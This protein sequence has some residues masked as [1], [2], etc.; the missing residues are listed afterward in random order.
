MPARGIAV[1][2]ARARRF[3]LV[4]GP[5]L[6]AA[7]LAA[8]PLLVSPILRAQESSGTAIARAQG[9]T[10]SELIRKLE[11]DDWAPPYFAGHVTIFD[12][13][14]EDRRLKE[15][16]AEPYTLVEVG[17]YSYRVSPLRADEGRRLFFLYDFGSADNWRTNERYMWYALGVSSAQDLSSRFGILVE[18]RGHLM[19]IVGMPDPDGRLDYGWSCAMCHASLDAQGRVVAGAPNHLYDSG[20]IRHRGLVEN[21]P[22]PGYAVP[23]YVDRDIPLERLTSMGP[24]RMDRNSDRVENPVKIPSLWGLRENRSGLYANGG[25]PN[26]WFA[27]ARHNGGVHPSS[28]YIEAMIAYLLEIEPPP[29]P[30]M[31]GEAESRGEDVFKRAGCGSCHSGP[32]YTN[33][34]VVPVETI[35]TDA[36][37][38][39]QEFPK[40]YRVPSLRR[41]DLDRLFLHDGSIAALADLFSRKRT[42]TVKGHEYGLDLSDQ[43]KK[44]LVAFL[45]SL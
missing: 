40:A 27:L 41:L 36:A 13:V 21:D 15:M 45:L 44:D 35:G 38:V 31:R 6:A 28:E 22:H 8:A 10:F 42:A 7:G 17:D 34:G 11:S 26:F 3:V 23:G 32:Y 4:V 29:N 39:R 1:T 24:G 12:P 2:V 20:R 33:G 43:E 9:K 18:P 19:G 14:E 25:G 16:L 37:R 30:K 5:G